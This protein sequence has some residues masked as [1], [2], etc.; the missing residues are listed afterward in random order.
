MAM[1]RPIIFSAAMV[2]A[3]LDG[4]KSQT[5]RVV[6]P[7]TLGQSE[8]GSPALEDAKGARWH[9][10][11]A[12]GDLLWVRETCRAEELDSG[13]DGVRYCAD[14]AFIEIEN[15]PEA[16]SR[17]VDLAHYGWHYARYRKVPAIHMP[18]WASRLTLLVTEVR[19]ERLQDISEADALAEG[20]KKVRD[21]CHVIKGF[22]YD[23]AGLCH[24]HAFTPF[25][26][27]WD[28]INGGKSGRAWDDNPM[29]AAISFA[30]KRANIDAVTR[31]EAA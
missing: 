7:L 13:L 11:W 12:P 16:A 25:A 2:R 4:T 21:Y 26:K 9:V 17:W 14:K 27:L 22:D 15:T 6:H 30:L 29:V 31:K 10:P 1:E 24:T 3:I 19:I 5:R 23:E 28:S 20:V 18:R 8:R